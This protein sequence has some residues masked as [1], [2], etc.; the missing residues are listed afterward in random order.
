MTYAPAWT[1]ADETGRVAPAEHAVRAADP[2]E[3]AAAVNRRR[4]LVYL[5]GQDFS[6]QL[7]AGL[8]VRAATFDTQTAPPFDN[9]RD[10]IETAILSPA[11]GGLGGSPATPAAMDWLWPVAGAEE[12]KVL[13]ARNPASG[14]VGLLDELNA[15]DWTDPT[16]VGPA[17]RSGV[18]AVHV[19]ELR[20]AVEW[21]TRGRWRLPIYL[22][23]GLLSILPGTPWIGGS[24]ANNGTDE[25][26]ASGFALIRTADDPPLG[27]V[28]ATVRP[29]TAIA[30]T[31]DTACQVEVYH[32]LRA[33][34]FVADPPTW[35]QYDP[36]AAAAWASPG[37]A[38]AGDATLLGSLSLSAGVPGSLSGSAVAA[39][40]QA[41]I[42]GAE[43]S[44][45]IRRS[46]TGYE[47]IAV[48][49]ELTVEFD[50]DSP[51]N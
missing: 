33:I 9:L 15:G 39:A 41:M 37:G 13:V 10:A 29:A 48:T 51:P 50:L 25:L 43:Q 46:D 7:G 19:N 21:I 38:G 12:N 30:V 47:T 24:I 1:N 4:R 44:F 2:T 34:D 18:R 45:L 35:N 16:L 28:G 3:L 11:V 23:G 49:A 42:D 40:V 26:R 36:S 20:Q 17:G 14:Q 5:T 8:P 27:I 31:A 6:S 22:P 32:V